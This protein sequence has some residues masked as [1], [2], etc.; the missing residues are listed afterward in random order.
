[1]NRAEKYIEEKSTE[2]VF[3]AAKDWIINWHLGRQESPKTAL[4]PYSSSKPRLGIT[5]IKP[6]EISHSTGRL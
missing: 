6:R 2:K 4:V 5:L 1:M 3:G